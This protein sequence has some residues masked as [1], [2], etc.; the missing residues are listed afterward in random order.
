MVNLKEFM[1][2]EREM[3]DATRKGERLGFCPNCSNGV[4]VSMM[5]FRPKFDNGEE[6]LCRICL[7]CE[8]ESWYHEN[9]L[10]GFIDSHLDAE[11][12]KIRGPKP[13]LVEFDIWHGAVLGIPSL[14]QTF[15]GSGYAGVGKV[16]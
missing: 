14:E 15:E 8:Y 13:K 9:I 6:F 12:R 16:K 5:W 1:K 3:Y 10:G 7:N 11:L 4:L 2:E